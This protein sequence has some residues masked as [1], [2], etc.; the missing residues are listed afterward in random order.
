MIPFARITGPDLS[1]LSNLFVDV[2]NVATICLAISKLSPIRQFSGL[3][4]KSARLRAL[5][6]IQ[7]DGLP[8]AP[9]ET[10]EVC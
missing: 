5:T 3:G 4:N 1:Q 6:R 10:K 2:R 8:V 9:P 7:A